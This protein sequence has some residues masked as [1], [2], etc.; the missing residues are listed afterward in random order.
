[1]K[2]QTFQTLP[3][4]IQIDFHIIISYIINLKFC[5]GLLGCISLVFNQL[6]KILCGNYYLVRFLANR[7]HITIFYDVPFYK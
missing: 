3:Y 2:G 5:S 6:N 4:F 1:M 7:C